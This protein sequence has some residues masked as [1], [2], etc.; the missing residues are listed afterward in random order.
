[1]QLSGCHCPKTIQTLMESYLGD[2]NAEA[3]LIYLDDGIVYSKDFASY[4][5]SPGIC[6]I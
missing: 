3:L 1:M 6:L 2:L 4:L 5:K